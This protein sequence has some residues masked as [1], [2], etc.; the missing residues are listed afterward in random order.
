MSTHPGLLRLLQET[1]AAEGITV[2]Y[3]APGIGGTDT[4]AIH[5]AQDG[6]PAITV[7]TPCRYI[8]GPAAIL[9][10]NDLSASVRL[11]SAAL[12][13]LTPDDLTSVL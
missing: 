7:A 3:K 8:H 5:L 9:N 11:V 1:A 12:R 6:I 13:R 2:Q 10:L 4:G